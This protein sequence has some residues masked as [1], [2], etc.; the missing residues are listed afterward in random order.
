M[1]VHL[2]ND[3]S[4]YSWD[5]LAIKFSVARTE[6]NSLERQVREAVQL[7]NMDPERTINTQM[8]FVAPAIQRMT[9]INLLDDGTEGTEPRGANQSGALTIF[10][11]LHFRSPNYIYSWDS[12]KQSRL[13][14]QLL[15]R[16]RKAS[17]ILYKMLF[18]Y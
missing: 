17:R 5:P 4:E 1:A 15:S 14:R 9:H 2:N 10:K 6:P 11:R 16:L 12:D 8:K 7:A 18:N 13:A 3:H